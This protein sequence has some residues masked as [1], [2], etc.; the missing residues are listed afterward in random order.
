MS[1]GP[2]VRESMPRDVASIEKLYPDAFPD[3]DLLP[4]VGEL[5]RDAPIALSLVGLI[6]GSLVGHVIFTTC[7]IDACT[8]Q[9]AL[10]GPLVV[11]P[12]RQRQGVGTAMVHAG[13]QRLKSADVTQV[14]V[15]GD[16][17]YYGRF[18]FVRETGV[19]PPFPLPVEWRGAWQA[20]SLSSSAEPPPQGKLTVPPP[21]RQ[22]ALW[23]P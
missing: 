12:A 15:L 5:L 8:D 22:P 23:A 1:E 13:L 9:V 4:L 20:L 17:A 3:E 11:T 2:N 19:E 16:P 18:G 21:W 7:G 14:Y 10:L 6:D